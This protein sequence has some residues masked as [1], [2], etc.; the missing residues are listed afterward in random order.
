MSAK[1]RRRVTRSPCWQCVAGAALARPELLDGL[2]HSHDAHHHHEAHALP[3]PQ[4]R[5]LEEPYQE[6]VGP[7]QP[8]QF[9]Y[10]AGRYPNHVDRTHRSAARA[11]PVRAIR[12]AR[13]QAPALYCIPAADTPR[14]RAPVL[15]TLYMLMTYSPQRARVSV[16]TAL[17]TD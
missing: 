13:S 12:P 11:P 6:P 2:E 3:A 7:P 1:S 9:T 15:Y 17:P 8:Y 5:L 14:Q 16:R 4:L 10:Q